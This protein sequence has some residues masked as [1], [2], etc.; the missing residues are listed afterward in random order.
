M[1]DPLDGPV[2]AAVLHRLHDDRLIGPEALRHGAARLDAPPEPAAW[3]VFVDR[4]LRFLGAAL[5]LAGAV[6]FFAYNWD[7]LGRFLQMGMLLVAIVAAAAAAWGR[8]DR[9]VGQ[10]LLLGA[11][12]LVGP[13]LG[14]FGTTYQT[15]A[16][17]YGLFLAWSALTLAWA[18]I[19]RLPALW[20]LQVVLWNVSLLLYWEQ[21]VADSFF[22]RGV[23][24]YLLAASINGAAWLVWE[25]GRRAGAAWMAGRW[26]PRTLLLGA[27]VPIVSTTC[28]WILDDLDT[29]YA[30]GPALL[31]VVLVA[32]YAVGRWLLLD[33]GLL[34][35]AATALIVVTST[36]LG[37]VAMEIA[38]DAGD[39]FLMVFLFAVCGLT[40]AA[41]VA[42]ASWWLTHLQPVGDTQEAA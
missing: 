37:K 8:L 34:A 12:V 5:V 36:V 24:P 22:E 29:D 2:V 35:M 21:V 6:Y 4:L 28:V 18:V 42:A 3:A 23:T 19:A 31:L 1:T 20:I 32:A 14:V 10:A 40:V 30:L 26:A 15:G 39:S 27:L 11:T 33:R 17:P 41:K 25:G 13:L 16:D 7:A 9:P 38:D